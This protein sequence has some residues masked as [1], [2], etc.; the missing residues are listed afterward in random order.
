MRLAGRAPG[1]GVV[2]APGADAQRGQ[3]QAGEGR[4]I[5]QVFAAEQRSKAGGGL[6]WRVGGFD[7]GGAH[8]GT[9]FEG[10]GADA[11]A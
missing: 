4:Q 2:V 10:G 9:D 7:E 5:G 11:G 3:A 6:G 1:G 8:F